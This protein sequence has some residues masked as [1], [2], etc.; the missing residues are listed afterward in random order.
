MDIGKVEVISRATNTI[1]TIYIYSIEI[2][3][4]TGGI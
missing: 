2:S 3:M 4:G 1:P